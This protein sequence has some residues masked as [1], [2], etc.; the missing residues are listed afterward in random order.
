MFTET[1][2]GCEKKTGRNLAVDT[3]RGIAILFV[4]LG[5]TIACSVNNANQSVLLNII[6]TIQMPMFFLISGYVVRY[7]RG[8]IDGKTFADHIKRR[9]ITYLWPWVVWSAIIKGFLLGNRDFL[10]I[11]WL[12]W[13]MDSGYWF[14]FSQWTIS[15]I[16][17][18]AQ[19][20]SHKLFKNNSKSL[21][22][23]RIPEMLVAIF[24]CTCLACI[25]ALVGIK[26]G[27]SFLAIKYSLY[28]TPYFLA[29]FVFGQL[30]TVYSN[31][32]WFKKAT[33]III[34]FSVLVYIFLLVRF[35]FYIM[36]ES[37]SEILLRISAS[38]TGCIL[39][40]GLVAKPST[41]CINSKNF[42]GI[43]FG[44]I[45]WVGTNSMQIY[46]WHTLFLCMVK[47][48]NVPIQTI[49]GTILVL[50]NYAL[51]LLL[52]CTIILLSKQNRILTKILY[53]E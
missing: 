48:V 44:C 43:L 17:A 20:F 14:L 22:L 3:L 35:N 52:T 21:T 9:T 18:A 42:G 15:I 30:Q 38:I 11:S 33:N 31:S 1:P 5:H 27:L 28:Y 29:G 19:F 37:V 25:L 45:R 46:L 26:I 41:L 13:H 23:T 24:F 47:E 2:S 53:G 12:A 51:T 16:F 50:M 8:I 6:W 39:L 49:E 36:G 32:K 7:S 34:A 10:N 4:V 40:V